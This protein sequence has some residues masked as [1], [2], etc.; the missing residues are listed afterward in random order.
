MSTKQQTNNKKTVRIIALLACS[1]L[2]GSMQLALILNPNIFLQ[3]KPVDTVALT[4]ELQLGLYATLSEFGIRVNWISGDKNHKKIRAPRD[5][6]LHEPYTA[7]VHRFREIGGDILNA[8]SNPD[9]NRKVIE[10][11]VA[12]KSVFEITLIHD[13]NIQRSAGK[14]AICIDDF[15]S[16]FSKNIR[17]FFELEC[18]IN[19]AVL[20]GLPYSEK[21]SRYATEHGLEVLL[22]LPMQAQ[23]HKQSDDRFLLSGKLSEKEVKTK[24]QNAL[25]TVP[26]ACGV[27]NHMGSAASLN[28]P[29]LEIVMTEINRGNLFFLDSMTHPKS[30]GY[31]I[32]KQKKTPTAFNNT[33]LDSIKE[34]PFIRQQ[35]LL[36][37]EM[38]TRNGHAIGIGHPEKLTLQILKE[39]MPRLAKMGF[40]FVSLSELVK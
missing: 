15:G 32:A 19:V 26:D 21:I 27:N 29:L 25:A 20:P 33:F 13:K 1:V 38:A 22:H 18:T 8:Q 5:L 36:L 23:N 28:A 14:I 16:G 3:T 10:V 24:I 2:L 37:A 40:Q 34:T 35:I 30:L 17:S 31:K 11:G 39:E 7:L 4:R 9:G 6:A 12:G